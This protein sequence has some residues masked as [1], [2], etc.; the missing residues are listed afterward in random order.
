MRSP[1]GVERHELGSLRVVV[2]DLFRG[3][4]DPHRFATSPA[5]ASFAV[6]GAACPLR[7]RVRQSYQDL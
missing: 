1:F 3:S 5:M 6:L 4:H 2:P 7:A